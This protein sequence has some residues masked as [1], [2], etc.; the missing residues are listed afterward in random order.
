MT[1]KSHLFL[2]QSLSAR[3]LNIKDFEQSNIDKNIDLSELQLTIKEFT[4]NI[5]SVLDY[6]LFYLHEKIYV[7]RLKAQ[8]ATDDE[9]SR[10]HRRISF[11]NYDSEIAFD[12]RVNKMFPNIKSE[13]PDLYQCIYDVQEFN[14]DNSADSWFTQADNLANHYKHRKLEKLGTR[15]NA[16]IEYL[17]LPGGIKL[18]NNTFINN[19]HSIVINGIPL[20][21][22]NTKELGAVNFKG[23]IE[24]FYAFETTK[25]PVVET[26]EWILRN[27]VLTVHNLDELIDNIP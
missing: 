22:D 8:D 12:K 21:E 6:T 13:F 15:E 17:E 5:E 26:L 19:K 9:I 25:L 24:N 4:G 14:F 3:L 20:T 16:E 2:L 27:T 23:T 18:S 10:Q 11:I 1:K 7:P